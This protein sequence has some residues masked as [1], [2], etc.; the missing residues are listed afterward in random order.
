MKEEMNLYKIVRPILS[1]IFKLLYMPR[2][3]G[4]E[5]IPKTG[6]AVI[7]GTHI[8]YFDPIAI[9]ASTKR[10]VYFIAKKELHE[11]KFKHIFKA[12]GTIPV[13]RSTKNPL[14]RAKAESALRDGKLIGIFPEGTTRKEKGELLPFKYGAVSMAQ[15]ANV[16]IIPFAIIGNYRPFSRVKIIYGEAINIEGFSLEEANALLR[17]KIVELINNNS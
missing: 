15:K 9:M 12:T 4:R 10:N 1:I 14:A 17:T 8:W 3:I 5:N 16:K 13:D 2:I 11:G 6:G 7:A